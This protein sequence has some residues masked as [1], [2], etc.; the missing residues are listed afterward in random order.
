[1]QTH[2]AAGTAPDTVPMTIEFEPPAIRFDVAIF[3]NAAMISMSPDKIYYTTER[4]FSAGV[5]FSLD[6]WVNAIRIR[7]KVAG[8]PAR[9]DISAY[10]NPIE[11]TGVDPQTIMRH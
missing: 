11:I 8:S 3:D 10:F 5:F 9:Y 2:H 7:N 1:M 6:Q 4:E